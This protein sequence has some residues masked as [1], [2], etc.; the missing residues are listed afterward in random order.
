MEIAKVTPSEVIARMR[1]GER[2]VFIDARSATDWKAADS[3]L[4][5]A[6]HVPAE[7]VTRHLAEI[8]QGHPVVSYCTSRHEECSARVAREL[9]R[10]G[11]LNTHP[12]IGGLEAWRKAGYPV[13]PKDCNAT[14]RVNTGGAPARVG[15]KTGGRPRLCRTILPPRDTHYEGG[16]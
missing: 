11:F 8:P 14:P 4:P 5:G 13:E 2:F 3:K 10:R 16:K 15:V 9:T 1:S 6:I 12:L 7:E